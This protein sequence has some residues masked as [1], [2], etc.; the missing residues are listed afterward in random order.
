MC[1]A[2][3][4]TWSPLSLS[5]C[6]HVI[7]P[8][9]SGPCL[10]RGLGKPAVLNAVA[11][12]HHR[13]TTCPRPLSSDLP[14]S[15]RSRYAVALPKRRGCIQRCWSIPGTFRLLSPQRS[16]PKPMQAKTGMTASCLSFGEG[17]Q[18]FLHTWP[19]PRACAILRAYESDFH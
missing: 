18:Q 6:D 11:S 19:D 2:V 12:L 15:W 17:T 5:C 7:S 10:R 1:R 14:G 16:R 3:P 9:P 8:L 13:R 4:G